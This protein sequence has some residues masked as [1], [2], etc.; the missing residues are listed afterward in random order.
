MELLN[1]LFPT[2]VNDP[3]ANLDTRP[4]AEKERDTKFGELVASGDIETPHWREKDEDEW[5]KF[6]IFDQN[7][8]GSCVAQ[9]AAKMLGINYF[10][11]E[12]SYVHFSA[13]HIYQQRSNR[14]GGGMIGVEALHIAGRGVTLEDLAPSQNLTD[15]K[16]DGYKIA[17]YKVKV[18][19]VFSISAEPVVL[20]VQDI[21]VIAS[22]IQRTKKGVMVWFY[23]TRDEWKTEP[24]V[25]TKNLSLTGPR[26]VR[27][28]VTAVDF[29]LKNGKKYL[30]IE[31]SWGPEHG[32]GGRRIISED[33]FETRNW[34]NGYL[35]NFKFIE[36]GDV[37]K[38]R[39]TFTKNL[40]YGDSPE[41]PLPDVIA[42]QDILKFEGLFP[43]NINSTGYYGSVTARAVL[44]FQRKYKVASEAELNALQG[45]VVGP[46]TRE[47]LN[48]LYG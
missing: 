12:G 37:T 10:I 18:G 34:F 42:L 45:K 16:M 38:P 32:K 7:G 1:W 46:K 4:E 35:M 26:T 23:F 31:D 13:T 41:K 2:V 36:G 47:A 21:D 24:V 43:A 30:V 20:P 5:R 39:Y 22:V 8:S 6:P 17:P 33:F 44:A 40:N 27:H 11:N 48:Q 25:K 19:E 14:P 15:A 28:S 29:F 9:S 3:G